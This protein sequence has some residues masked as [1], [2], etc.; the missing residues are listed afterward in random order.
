M[1]THYSK[2]ESLQNINYPIVPGDKQISKGGS[3]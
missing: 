1:S 3:I 2:L